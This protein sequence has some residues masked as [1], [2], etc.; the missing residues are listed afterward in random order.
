MTEGFLFGALM[1]ILLSILAIAVFL[2]IYVLTLIQI[3]QQLNEIKNDTA[4][5]KQ[6]ND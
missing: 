6:H 4:F 2:F 5:L 3:R 1:A